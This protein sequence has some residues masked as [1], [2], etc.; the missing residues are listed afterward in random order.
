MVLDDNQVNTLNPLESY[1]LRTP[2][3]NIVGS[4]PST[5]VNV[6]GV[7]SFNSGTEPLFVVNGTDVGT[8]YINA[9]YLVADMKITSVRVLKGADASLYGVR[10]GNGVIVIKAK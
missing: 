9:A 10:G 1:L 2:G 5:R 7:S 8:S 3:V 6:R 4:G